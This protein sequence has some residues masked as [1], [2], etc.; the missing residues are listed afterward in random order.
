MDFA[1]GKLSEKMEMLFPSEP[2]DR[3]NYP[4]QN[5]VAA[6]SSRFSQN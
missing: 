4:Q 5:I 2:N 1:V 3:K 6:K